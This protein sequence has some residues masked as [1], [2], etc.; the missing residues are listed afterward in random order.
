LAS[1][2]IGGLHKSV[3][4]PSQLYYPPPGAAGTD[5]PLSG[6]RIAVSDALAINGVS[7][8]LSSRAWEA[9][10]P[11]ASK[12]SA[13]LV[14]DLVSMGAV[15]VGKT[16]TSQFSASRDWID[17]SAPF[18][19]RGDQYQRFIGSSAGASASLTGYNWLKY[20]VTDDGMGRYVPSL[21]ST[22]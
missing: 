15:I 20:I 12:E 7:R 14:K 11:E 8:T 9:V 16:K 4:V 18:T 22:S 6:I 19:P 17:V 2:G 13:R 1:L 5:K 10:H 21:R 3:A